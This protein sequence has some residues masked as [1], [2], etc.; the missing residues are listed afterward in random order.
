MRL[1]RSPR[2]K[3]LAATLGLPFGGLMQTS[4]RNYHRDSVPPMQQ[5]FIGMR[6]RNGLPLEGK[7]IEQ[8]CEGTPVVTSASAGNSTSLRYK[9]ALAI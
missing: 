4:N 1:C 8:P 2:L 3:N 6:G 9:E 7:R 5:R